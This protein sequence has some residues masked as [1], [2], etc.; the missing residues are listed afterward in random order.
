MNLGSKSKHEQAA[1]WLLASR[2]LLIVMMMLSLVISTFFSGE[3]SKN[4]A[5]L[6]EPIAFA[7]LVTGLSAFWLKS[8]PATT[9]FL[10]TQFLIDTILIT[11]VIYTTG[12]AISPFLFLYLP[13]V[14]LAAITISR[15]A[16]FLMA[17]LSTSAYVT[18]M[19]ALRSGYLQPADGSSWIALPSE[20]VLLQ[21]IG[22]ASAMFLVSVAS[23]FLGAR[24]SLSYEIIESSEADLRSMRNEQDK[25][26]KDLDQ[27]RTV[28]DQLKA[29]D[30]LAKMLSDVSSL[31]DCFTPISNFIGQSQVMEKVFALI[32]RV[33]KS[34]TTVLVTGESGTGKELVAKAIHRSSSRAAGPFIAVNCGAI[35]ETL[36][37][38]E[39]FGHKKGAF[40][41]A[42]S[43]TLGLVRQANGGTLFLDEIGELPLL[44]QTKLLRMLQE[45]IVKPVGASTEIPVNVRVIAATNK[46]LK[47][48]VAAGRFREDL[49]YRLHVIG[50]HLPPLRERKDDIP[51]LIN[52]LLRK[53]APES[54]K[55]PVIPPA[56]MQILLSYSYPGN[57]RE[58]ENIL[59]HAFVLG[60]DA[61]LPEHLPEQ[62][63]ETP[64]ISE[65]AIR[66]ADEIGF[67]VNLEEILS[68]L[69][70]RYLEAA[71]LEAHG[72]KKHAAELL[73]I[74]FRSFRYRLKKFGLAADDDT[75]PVENHSQVQ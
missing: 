73:G 34:D 49:Y 27:L 52:A 38:S 12:G 11:G 63:T 25:L 10:F 43:D 21:T 22:L 16:A 53:L 37:E 33:A 67:P 2:L 36:I 59:E 8:R 61:I 1:L 68:S 5:F 75:G 41:G 46:T 64:L 18:L 9:G 45:R 70:Q 4:S 6:Y 39:L 35:P 28:E 19:W 30:Q 60:G 54:A 44:M 62:V 26:L 50:I 66:T 29:H 7:L 55:I 56:T 3:N 74:N 13:V 69:E 40:T 14:M 51:I 47:K 15:N 65:T 71:M 20:G 42:D 57:V 58:L 24:L 23:H 31:P 17:A 32:K 72:V 48:E